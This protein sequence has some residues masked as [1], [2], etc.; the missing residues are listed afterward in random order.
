M[1]EYLRHAEI[2]SQAPEHIA[3]IGAGGNIG[4]LFAES[5]APFTT[6]ITGVVRNGHDGHLSHLDNYRQVDNLHDLVDYT[7]DLIIVA[8][9]NPIDSLVKDLAQIPQPTTIILPQ[10]GIVAT[11]TALKYLPPQHQ[12]I[13]MNV[14]TPVKDGHYNPDK[15]R[16]SLAPVRIDDQ[17]LHRID[18]LMR[19]AGF[20]TRIYPQVEPM[21]WTKLLTNTI[22]STG[23]ITGLTPLETFSDPTLYSLEL[24]GLKERIAILNE[25]GIKM[26]NFP[27][28]NTNQI[29]NIIDRLP[30]NLR[31]IPR[32]LIAYAIASKRDNKPPAAAQKLRDG[33]PHELYYYH[34]PFVELGE[35][36]GQ[37][38]CVDK[39]MLALIDL[40][41]RGHLDLKNTS[42]SELALILVTAVESKGMIDVPA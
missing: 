32:T 23:A 29:I 27:W 10:N 15:L 1:S 14:H 21:V 34:A 8:T 36:V 26:V 13:R 18:Q 4:G 37:V 9:P 17:A 25:S 31:K 35:S 3:I 2:L 28:L 41:S 38:S 16:T 6:R 11:A 24:R 42:A 30:G 5:L 19:K 39:G 40:H 20:D 33:K 7:P 12:I 22:G